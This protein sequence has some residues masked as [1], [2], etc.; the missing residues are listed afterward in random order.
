MQA[1]HESVTK[2]GSKLCNRVGSH[3]VSQGSESKPSR[4]VGNDI[5]PTKPWGANSIY[6]QF[7]MTTIVEKIINA[8]TSKASLKDNN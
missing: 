1:H 6:D 4:A 3:W 2:A 7:T 5:I 8:N